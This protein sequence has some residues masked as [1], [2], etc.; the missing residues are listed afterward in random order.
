MNNIYLNGR[1]NVKE[2]LLV[3]TEY[4]QIPHDINNMIDLYVNNK[5]DEIFKFLQQ[6]LE[7]YTK[8]WFKR[9]VSTSI[10]P[11]Y[12]NE[13]TLNFI[14]EFGVTFRHILDS[15]IIKTKL[16]RAFHTFIDE[17]ESDIFSTH[18][19]IM[20]EDEDML[21]AIV[22]KWAFEEHYIDENSIQKLD[23]Y[24]KQITMSSNITKSKPKHSKKLS[25]GFQNEENKYL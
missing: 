11:I 2:I 24:L 10:D 18:N 6:F 20:K 13:L 16:R 25:I 19:M 3:R 17:I 8:T 1:Y 14:K 15:N 7:T 5:Y 4:H 22:S 9:Y 12:I 21:L 23:L